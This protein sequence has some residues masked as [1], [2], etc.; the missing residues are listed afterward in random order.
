MNRKR[1]NNDDETNEY[2]EPD[3]DFDDFDEGSEKTETEG[4]DEFGSG[5]EG[6]ITVESGK[7]RKNE[8]LGFLVVKK[9]KRKNDK[10]ELTRDDVIIGRSSKSC[11]FVLDD[12]EVSRIHCRIRKDKD[13]N[14]FYFFDC[15][16]TNG[17]LV[18]NEQVHTKLLKSHDVITLGENVEIVFIQV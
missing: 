15:G 14:E 2:F 5:N 7:R 1:K 3:E 4:F 13:K 16:S 6:E 12:D 10:Y 8:I 11:D 17:T 9:G 18:N